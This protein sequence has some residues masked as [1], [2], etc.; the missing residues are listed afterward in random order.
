MSRLISLAIMLTLLM[1]AC[2]APEVSP[3]T[4]TPVTAGQDFIPQPPAPTRPFPTEDAPPP[5]TITPSPTPRQ[6]VTVPP[7]VSLATAT[8]TPPTTTVAPTP[9]IRANSQQVELILRAEPSQA[10]PVIGAIPPQTRLTVL[11][12]T[13]DGAWLLVHTGWVTGWTAF[14]AGLIQFD[15]PTDVSRLPTH[16]LAAS[17]SLTPPL[18]TTP[19]LTVT[20]RLTTTNPRVEPLLNQIPLVV[21]HDGYHTCAAHT[22]LNHLLPSVVGG[23]IIGPHAGDFVLD[24]R[25]GVLFED[26]GE[27]FRLLLADSTARFADGEKYLSFDE[28]RALFAAERIIWT[29]YFGQTPGRGVTGCDLAVPQ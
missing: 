6:I 18:R 1:A 25:Y 16:P 7:P 14:S 17:P 20:P 3:E 4:A 10:A 26:T 15:S 21:H 9:A 27:G 5:P 8:T 29:G 12:R 2:V 28:A 24:N 23:H 19:S 22:G 11:Q 13:A